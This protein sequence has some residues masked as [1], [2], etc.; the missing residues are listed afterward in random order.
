[1]A[2]AMEFTS[3]VVPAHGLG[4]IRGP[5]GPMDLEGVDYRLLSELLQRSLYLISARNP[6]EL[7]WSLEFEMGLI[8]PFFRSKS[9]PPNTNREPGRRTH[10]RSTRS[11]GEGGRAALAKLPTRF[12][13][14]NAGKFVAIAI[15]GELLQIA[16]TFDDL[17]E[18]LRRSPPS[19]DYYVSRVGRESAGELP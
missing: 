5:R 9:V 14:Q 10:P 2:S 15:G 13:E 1:M 11:I 7:I 4:G 18:A 16:E 8:L 3:Q 19:Q 12:S 6:T 17:C